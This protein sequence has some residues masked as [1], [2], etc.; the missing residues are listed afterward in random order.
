MID[1]ELKVSGTIKGVKEEWV[2]KEPCPENLQDAIST[3][4]EEKVFERFLAQY[5]TDLKNKSRQQKTGKLSKT[6]L[7]TLA[8][9]RIPSEE[10]MAVVGRGTEMKALVE[11]Y[12]A[13]VE[14][15]LTSDDDSE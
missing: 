15:E 9:D 11:K 5:E 10:F 12:M 13:M 8:M 2:V 6:R 4:G 14:R 7:E 1:K 3:F